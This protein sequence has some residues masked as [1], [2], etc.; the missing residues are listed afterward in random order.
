MSMVVAVGPTIRDI[1][2]RS[3]TVAE[4]ALVTDSV[5]DRFRVSSTKA[6]R[7]FH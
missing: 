1:S 6:R 3:R 2:L 7:V 5:G 4:H